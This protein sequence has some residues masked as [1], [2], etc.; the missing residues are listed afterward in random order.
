[1]AGCLKPIVRKY[2]YMN[3]QNGSKRVRRRLGHRVMARLNSE[4]PLHVHQELVRQAKRGNITKAELVTQMLEYCLEDL[5]QTDADA[6][7]SI[8]PF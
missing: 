2:K 1:M 7:G 3:P 5:H 6:D 8:A 4:I